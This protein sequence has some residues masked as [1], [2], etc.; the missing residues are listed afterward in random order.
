MICGW[1]EARDDERY[2]WGD[3]YRILFWEEHG[4]GSGV[5]DFLS[6]WSGLVQREIRDSV[7]DFSS[8]SSL[9]SKRKAIART[10]IRSVLKL[11]DMTDDNG[12]PYCGSAILSISQ[13][14]PRL[15]AS[16]RYLLHRVLQNLLNVSGSTTGRRSSSFRNRCHR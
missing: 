3:L 16:R 5:D 14:I 15:T 11:P 13:S 7:L 2:A 12:L 6:H 4:W 10:S 1:G 8:R 9:S